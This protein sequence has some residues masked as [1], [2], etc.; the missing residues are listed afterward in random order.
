M[1]SYDV[2]VVG[3]GVVGSAMGFA[4]GKQGRKVLVIEKSLQEPDL[5]VGELMQPAGVKRLYELGL[6]GCLE[7]ID[8]PKV[9]GY[10]LFLNKDHGVHLPYPKDQLG[11]I[12]TGNSFHHGKFIVALR[13]HLKS[14]KNVE[15]I[16]GNVKSL[17]EEDDKVIGVVYKS[18]DTESR[19]YAP[20]TIVCDGRNSSLRNSFNTDEPTASTI[21]VGVIIKDT[22]LPF[23]NHGHVFLT[24]TGPILAY[25][26]GTH[27]TRLLID[28]PYPPPPLHEYLV[29]VTAPQLPDSIRPSF[30]NAV[31]AKKNPQY[32]KNS[33]LDGKQCLRPGVL[34]LGDAFNMRHPLTGGGMTVGLADAVTVRDLLANVKDL[35]DTQAVTRQLKNLYEKR[36][37]YAATVNILSWALY[38]VFT[39]SNDPILPEMRKACVAYLNAGWIFTSGPVSLLSGLNARPASLMM[40]FFSVAIFAVLRILW[41]FPTPRKIRDSY[42]LLSAASN[43]VVPLVRAEKVL[44]FLPI[45][46]RMLLL[47]GKSQ[48]SHPHPHT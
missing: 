21:F 35:T 9:H 17:V 28:V 48:K 5:I 11:N 19:A 30:I 31:N 37:G 22:P 33:K 8:S 6:E 34:L 40:H 44:S 26:I 47:T 12:Q 20:L 23:P 10:A 13:E 46:C 43:I 3:A 18:G 1:S 16:Q 29:N 38:N 24:Q 7:G 27:D 41:P 45:L 25:Q 14:N 42:R 15:L 36:K 32:M 2:I 39:A 4:L